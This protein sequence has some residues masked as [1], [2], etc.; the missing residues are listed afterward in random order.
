M[1][2]SKGIPTEPV[3]GIKLTVRSLRAM[4]EGEQ[5]AVTVVLQSGEHSETRVLRLLTEQYYELKISKGEISEEKFEELEHAAELCGA[6]RCGENLLSYGANSLQMLSK[7][8]MR[9]G[10]T[11]AVA[12]RAAE[13]LRDRGLI[14]ENEDM[15]REIEKCL[16]K[17]WGERR[18][19]SHLWDRGFGRETLEAVG[20]ILLEVDFSELCAKLI[21]KHY[22]GIPLTSD[23]TRKMTAGLYR[24]G[25][26]PEEIRQAIR[27]LHNEA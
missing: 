10:Y 12:L 8:I 21:K 3:G 16:R 4:N 2:N 22:G 25:Y 7:K 27:I 1:N 19:R 11:G 13:H 24:Y 20:D 17:L 15:R 18:I 26:K 23:E 6:I 5:I 9:H 14:N